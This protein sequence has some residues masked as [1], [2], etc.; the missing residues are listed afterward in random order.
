MLIEYKNVNIYQQND[1]L[2]LSDVCFNVGEGELVYIVGKVGSGKSSLLKTIY[3]ELDIYEG[4]TATVMDYDLLEIKRKHIPNLRKQ[5]GVIFQD[6]QLLV[7]RTVKKNLEFVLKATGWDDKEEIK[8]RIN[9]VLEEVGMSEKADKMPHE[10]SGGEQ[11]RIAIARAILNKP[12]LIIADEPTGNLDNATTEYIMNLLK[13]LVENGTSVVMTTH[14]LAVIEK[15]P[16]IIYQCEDGKITEKTNEYLK[17]SIPL[18]DDSEVEK[19]DETA[20]ISVSTTEETEIGE[21]DINK[22]KF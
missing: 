1:N 20:N 14:N 5:L 21:E 16:G 2:I 3:Q 18:E 8:E 4:D 9:E 11:Q 6:F 22:I 7:D 13:H 17:S 10:L 15:H 12:Q 19:N